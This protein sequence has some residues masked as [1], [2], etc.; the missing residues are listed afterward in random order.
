MSTNRGK[1]REERRFDQ[2]YL[3]AHIHGKQVHRDYAA[4]YFRWGFAKSRTNLKTVLDVGCGPETPLARVLCSHGGYS[5]KRPARYVGVDLNPI[6]SKFE[7]NKIIEIRERFDFVG[8]FRELLRD[9]PDGF[10]TVCNFEVLEHMGEKDQLALLRAMRA[11]LSPQGEILLSTPVRQGDH[12]AR[13]HVRE[14]TVEELE[15]LIEDAGL[16]VLSRFGTYGDVNR[17]KRAAREK[18]AAHQ[19]TFEDLSVYYDNEV[20]ST[21]LAPL[22]PDVCKNNLWILREAR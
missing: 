3:S 22:Y 11:C 6:K 4:H 15:G 17:I 19:K 12:Q 18:D 13:N 1:P 20:L 16:R 14:V 2:T 21:F 10:D 5:G 9:Y 7:K 8:R